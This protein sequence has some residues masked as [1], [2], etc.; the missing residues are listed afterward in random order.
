[1]NIILCSISALQNSKESARITLLMLAQELQQQGHTV[2]IAAPQRK[3]MGAK[4][5][6]DTINV[7]RYNSLFSL[8]LTVRKIQEMERWK[9]DI[10]HGFSATPLFAIPLFFS[11][12]SN[13]LSA[14]SSLTGNSNVFIYFS[15]HCSAI[16]SAIP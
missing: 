4:E 10:I 1:M 8:P 16:A 13:I 5:V 9:A 14:N 7:Y 12:L 3:G 11:R 15:P 2:V 6:L